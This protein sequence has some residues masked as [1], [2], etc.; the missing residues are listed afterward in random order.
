MYI[1]SESH[2]LKPQE[3]FFYAHDELGMPSEDMYT[4][5]N[6]GV[7]YVIAVRPDFEA[8]ALKILKRHFAADVIGRVEAGSGKVE[9]ESQY[10]RKTVRYV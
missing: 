8:D 2:A 3:L 7:G 6:N 5:F 9:I 10:E 1:S 4:R